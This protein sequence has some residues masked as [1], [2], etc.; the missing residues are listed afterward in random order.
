ML[1]CA[2]TSERHKPK[3]G[4]YCLADGGVVIG[5]RQ[6]S[7][8]PSVDFRFDTTTELVRLALRR[9]YS[10]LPDGHLMEAHQWPNL[11]GHF[12]FCETL[13][14]AV[15]LSPH[16][17][18][19][20]VEAVIAELMGKWLRMR[21]RIQIRIEEKVP[22]GAFLD[23][24]PIAEISDDFILSCR[25]RLKNGIILEVE[26]LLH[27]AEDWCGSQRTQAT[28]SSALSRPEA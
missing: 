5:E 19:E 17:R 8:N 25:A 6:T 28:R 24:I 27:E 1:S 4:I 26:Y 11:H 13:T 14:E 21:E 20:L 22:A 15:S 23:L 7:G 12:A 16:E 2:T 10:G 9:W 18:D 3:H